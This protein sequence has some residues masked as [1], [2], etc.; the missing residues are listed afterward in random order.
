M[1]RRRFPDW[2]RGMPRDMASDYLGAPI[3]E[4][5]IRP[6]RIGDALLYDR[7]DLDAYMDAKRS[8]AARS[9][10]DWLAELNA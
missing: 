6:V 4:T 1:A 10:E 7:S 2:P 5:A 8:A 3:E 9:Q